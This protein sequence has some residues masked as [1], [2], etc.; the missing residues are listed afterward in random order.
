MNGKILL[1]GVL[2]TTL[3]STNTFAQKCD[4]KNYNHYKKYHGKYHG[5]TKVIDLDI[6]NDSEVDIKIDEFIE[7]LNNDDYHTYVL[8]RVI[9]K[10]KSDKIFVK[11]KK[12]HQYKYRKHHKRKITFVINKAWNSAPKIKLKGESVINL[13]VGDDFI[14]PGVKAKDRED[15]RLK[16]YVEIEGGPVDTSID[17]TY[18]LIYKVTDSEGLESSVERT[19]IVGSGEVVAT[20]PIAVDN[21]SFDIE[22]NLPAGTIVGTLQYQDGGSDITSIISDGSFSIDNMGVI[23]TNEAFDFE[24]AASYSV[25]YTLSNELGDTNGTLAINVIDDTTEAWHTPTAGEAE[26]FVNYL[27]TCTTNINNHDHLLTE[28]EARDLYNNYYNPNTGILSEFYYPSGV[29][30]CKGDDIPAFSIVQ[31]TD[32]VAINF[33]D[34]NVPSLDGLH[35]LK[36]SSTLVFTGMHNLHNISALDN[37]ETAST[38]SFKDSGADVAVE[39]FNNLTSNSFIDFDNTGFTKISGFNALT[40]NSEINF[41]NNLNLTEISGFSVYDGQGNVTLS[42]NPLLTVNPF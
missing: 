11:V 34:M 13:A 3:L 26:R 23:T 40:N 30:F 37:I 35:N 41:I 24:T 22:E 32:R 25:N 12:N 42:N 8:K 27:Q 18:T 4:I 21:Q 39:G 16:K 6:Q 17:S 28:P 36:R 38:I 31:D 15:G 14:D 20:K 9:N 29:L 10:Y 7:S 1:G 5:H 33:Q 19:V 2:V